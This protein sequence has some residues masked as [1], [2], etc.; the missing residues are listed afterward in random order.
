MKI[1]GL[2]TEY[3]P[4]HNGHKYHMEQALE[5]TGADAALVVMSGNFVQRGTP[6]IMPK[7][8]RT[9]IALKSGAAA[10][11]ELPVCYASGSAEYFALG[12]VSLFE[13]L[14]CVNSICF[15]TECK[16]LNALEEI[17]RILHEE[18]EPYRQSLKVH[19][20]S[21]L[22][23]P[24]AR[25]RALEEYTKDTALSSYMEKPNNILGIEYLKA[26]YRLESSIIPYSVQRKESNYHDTHLCETYSSASAIRKLLAFSGNAVHM[27]SDGMY[28][29]PILSDIL[30]RLEEQ[31]PPICIRLLEETHRTRYPV[32]ANDFSLILKY[33]LLSAT[34]QWLMSF[35]DV[36]EDLANRILKYRNDFISFD[37]FCDLLKTRQLTY[38][39]IS[40]ALL[41]ILLDIRKKDMDMWMSA[42][43]H[44]YARVLGFRKDSAGILTA[45]K[46]KSSVP[47]LTKLSYTDQMEE[48]FLSMLECDIFASNLYETVVTEKF[49]T[50]FIN[51]YEH[52]VVR[53]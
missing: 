29:E 43:M 46:E 14:G 31:V 36:T 34:P 18:P 40:R 33:R 10:V 24:Y 52:S 50:P 11:I 6:A 23:F 3:N 27:E 47:L 32:Y 13:R 15:G 1:V 2:I 37:Q 12:A 30:T 39:R 44:G 41:H 8:L 53:V 28:D 5:L 16:N 38:T 21:G 25:Q 17:A 9:E 7:H 35:V 26:L 22:S 49:K 19:M 4:F 42:D 51:E 20:K 48:P 45:L